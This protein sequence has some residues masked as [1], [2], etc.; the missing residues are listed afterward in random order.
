MHRY[1]YIRTDIQYFEEFQHGEGGAQKECTGTHTYIISRNFRRVGVHQQLSGIRTCMNAHKCKKLFVAFDDFIRSFL[2]GMVEL[3]RNAEARINSKTVPF[4]HHVS[5][6]GVWGGGG[7]LPTLRESRYG[8]L[9]ACCGMPCVLIGA[10]VTCT[11]TGRWSE[12]ES[13]A[14]VTYVKQKQAEGI[15]ERSISWIEVSKN[16]KTRNADQCR[17]HWRSVATGRGYS[18]KEGNDAAGGNVGGTS[19][20]EWVWK[21]ERSGLTTPPPLGNP[22]GL[23]PSLVLSL[24]G[25][26]NDVAV[27]ARDF[28]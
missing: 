23:I 9:S 2:A 19:K 21:R 7:A 8:L 28:S 20:V 16:I 1:T 6:Q 24:T 5:S 4:L 11:G 18:G 10:L 12:E 13:K 3:L 14:L 26:E 17:L 27:D 22:F 25:I 15:T